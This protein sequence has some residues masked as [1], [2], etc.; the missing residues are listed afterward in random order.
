[1]PLRA[2]PPQAMGLCGITDVAYLYLGVHIDRSNIC[3]LH[4]GLFPGIRWQ[5]SQGEKTL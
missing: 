2:L 1:M 4:R 5:V 3:H